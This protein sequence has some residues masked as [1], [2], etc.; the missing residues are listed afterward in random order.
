M[1]IGLSGYKII[2]FDIL[3]RGY[4][5]DV[6]KLG[7]RKGGVHISSPNFFFLLLVALIFWT[8]CIQKLEFV[9]SHKF[10]SPS[11]KKKKDNKKNS[12]EPAHSHRFCIIWLLDYRP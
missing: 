9:T 2:E 12:G 10:G 6:Y 8:L 1:G 7:I 11:K 3:R 5:S 4:I